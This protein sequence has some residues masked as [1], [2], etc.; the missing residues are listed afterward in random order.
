MDSKGWKSYCQTNL[1]ILLH[2]QLYVGEDSFVFSTQSTGTL[3]VLHTRTRTTASE[4]VRCFIYLFIFFIIQMFKSFSPE[5][6]DSVPHKISI[7]YSK[8]DK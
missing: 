7:C 2:F 8:A 4:K 6:I 1:A 3:V 5:M